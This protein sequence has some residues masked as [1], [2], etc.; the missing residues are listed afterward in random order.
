LS[1]VQVHSLVPSDAVALLAFASMACQLIG[2]YLYGQH[3]LRGSTKPNLASWGMWFFGAVVDLVTYESIEGSH[4]TANASP[5][6]CSVGVLSVS[7]VIAVMKI[8]GAMTGRPLAYQ[9]L[10][11]GGTYFVL[12][13]VAAVLAWVR[14]H[15]TLGNFVSVGTTVF[16]FFPMYRET[17]RDPGV[18]RL[19]PWAWWSAA[20]V[21]MLIAVAAGPG[22]SSPAL[23][24]LPAYY[25]MLHAAMIPLCLRKS[26]AL[27]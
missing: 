9:K 25:L 14:G 11:R 10:E 20:Y 18:E 1:S 15:G 21:F 13:D 17:Y 22:W 6:A 4:W 5:F 3:V 12:F 19:G 7:L 8:R 27:T 24:F 16:Q 23:Y 2:Y 26:A